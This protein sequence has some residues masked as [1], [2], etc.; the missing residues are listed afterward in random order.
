MHLKWNTVASITESA[1]VAFTVEDLLL[2][3]YQSN[4]L[5]YFFHIK[6]ELETDIYQLLSSICYDILS[7]SV[8]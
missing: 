2:A 6:L 5:Q 3:T 1:A 8:C 7:Y 4:I